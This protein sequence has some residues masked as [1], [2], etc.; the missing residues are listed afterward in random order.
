[1]LASQKTP[2][3][4]FF[5]ACHTAAPP[6]DGITVG[7]LFHIA[8]QA[9]AD[10]SPWRQLADADD[11]VFVPG[12]EED[13]RKRLDRVV[14]ADP[15]TFTLGDRTGPL[16]ILRV[17]EPDTLP[18]DTRWEGDLPGTTLATP[19]DLMQRAERLTWKQPRRGVVGELIRTH[20]PR[21]FVSD[22][23]TQMRGRYAAPPL[24]GVVRVPRI[25]EKGEIHFTSGYDP[26][27][28]LFHDRLQTFEVPPTPSRDE[29]V[30][31]TKQLL[32]PFS[33]YRFENFAAGRALTLAA[34]FTAIERPFLSVAPMF[35]VRSS[36]PGTGKG[37]FV[38]ALVS[39]AFDT[40][41]VVI[42][43]GGNDEEFEKR[44]DAVLLRSP[45]AILIDNANG[46]QIHGDRLESVITEGCADIRPL[47]VSE[48]V[49]V[50]NRSLISLTGNNPQVTGDMARRTLPLDILPASAD[51]ER[52]SYKWDPV[53]LTQEYRVGLLK[54]AFTAMRAFR[55]AGMPSQ[56][57]PAIGSFDDW[58]RRVRDLVY[59]LTDYDVGEVFRQ[60]KAEDPRRQND[61]CLLTAL[62]QCFH[63]N[64]FK[65]ADV[66]SVHERMTKGT[67]YP[68][69]DALKAAMEQA[70]HDALED[71]L[72]SRGVSAKLFGYWA[73]R[74]KGAHLGGYILQTDP[75][76]KTNVNLIRVRRT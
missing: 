58:S 15:R 3:R 40:A 48:I 35:V 54:F 36:M 22:Y 71:V 12:N 59:W 9:G 16:V 50:G 17:P 25:D 63:E 18:P 20:P 19:A 26:A 46:I 43:W 60:N 69:L 28:G 1:V 56:R 37:K 5:R 76:P 52:D 72:G 41:P 33:K 4:K 34:S 21:S 64:P 53:R 49:K 14:A 11:A 29:A 47:G 32:F 68:S 8:S 62:H 2:L 51:P 75:D 42:T 45:A 6:E 44:L 65:A 39:L 74:I 13:C 7:T 66:I 10:F 61:A 55:L 38:R 27:T 24:C 73:R 70:L 30:A 31:L 67:L 23:L 57:L